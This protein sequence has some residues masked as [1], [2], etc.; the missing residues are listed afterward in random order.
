MNLF[1]FYAVIV[2]C[3]DF[4]IFFDFLISQV[5]SCCLWC[6]F[7]SNSQRRS[8][9]FGINQLL[10]VVS[11]L[12]LCFKLI[13]FLVISHLQIGVL[14]FR[15]VCSSSTIITLLTRFLSQIAIIFLLVLLIKVFTANITNIQ[16]LFRRYD[17]LI[18]IAILSLVML[19]ESLVVLNLEV[20]AVSIIFIHSYFSHIWK[21][22]SFWDL[23]LSSSVFG[24]LCRH[25]I[26]PGI[27]NVSHAHCQFHGAFSSCRMR[28]GFRW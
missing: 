1:Y 5:V 4:F 13:I 9:Q 28:H 18:L 15:L 16:N 26:V 24:F 14:K 12:F 2:M 23:G 20:Q 3:H 22:W 6:R 19:Q 21:P 17:L 10:F 11:M 25:R 7:F 27:V 8:A